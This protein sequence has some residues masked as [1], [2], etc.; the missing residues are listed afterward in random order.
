VINLDTLELTFGATY[1]FNRG[2]HYSPLFV[3]YHA[4]QNQEVIAYVG[5]DGRDQ[6]RHFVCTLGDWQIRFT[7]VSE[8]ASE[9]PPEKIAGL[10]SAGSGV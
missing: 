10:Y 2:G 1:R 3:A 9:R 7:L 8:S 6:G 5:L 4:R